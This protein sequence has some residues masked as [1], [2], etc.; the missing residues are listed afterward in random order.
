M[1]SEL[2]DKVGVEGEIEPDF[3]RSAIFSDKT[4]SIPWKYPG[5]PFEQQET[6]KV[7]NEVLDIFDMWSLIEESYKGL[8]N[9]DKDLIEK[10]AY[11]FGRDPRFEGFDGNNESEYMSSASFI[12][13]ELDRY[14][15]FK[16]RDFNSHCPL[17]DSYNRMYP[18][19]EEIRNKSHFQDMTYLDIIE[20]LRERIHPEQ[21]K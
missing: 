18:K 6:P 1:L 21:R 16:G 19:F 3:I 15:E 14:E 9:E 8:S 7:V 5:I 20:I 11:P 13:N 10:E 2:Y 12:V 17:V 4:W